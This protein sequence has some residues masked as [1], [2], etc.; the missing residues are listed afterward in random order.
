MLS[1]FARDMGEHTT[2]P[3][4]IDPKHRARQH[5]RHRSFCDDLFLF[6]HGDKINAGAPSLNCRRSLPVLQRERGNVFAKLA[7]FPPRSGLSMLF[8]GRK[9][10]VIKHRAY[11]AWRFIGKRIAFE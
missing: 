10:V 7:S 6:R 3:G 1:H 8:G 5:F 4:K 2:L 9:A 11:V